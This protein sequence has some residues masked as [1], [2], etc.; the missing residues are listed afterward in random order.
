[1]EQA[2][3]IRI[4]GEALL[5]GFPSTPALLGVRPRPTSWRAAGAALIMAGFLLLAGVVAIVPPHAPWLIGAVLGGAILA[6][7]RWMERYTL[8][9]V[10]GTCPK[11]GERLKVKPARL[12]VP[13]PAMCEAC[14]HESSLSFDEGA[15]QG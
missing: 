2:E 3:R 12:R 5:F 14:H 4:E 10:E 9:S 13:H 15:L 1:M 6:R 8:E 11:C 7:R